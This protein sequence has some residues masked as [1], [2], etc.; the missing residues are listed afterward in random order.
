VSFPVR[1]GLLRR[2]VSVV[3]AVDGVS[4]AEREG[5]T[6]GV[7]DESG[8]GKTTLGLAIL[9]LPRLRRDRARRPAHRPASR[10]RAAP[11]RREMQIVFQDPFGSLPCLSVRQII[12]DCA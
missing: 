9:Q 2:T 1:G 4:V 11:L 8:S 3:R 5:Q 6:V 10:P 12:E 7:V